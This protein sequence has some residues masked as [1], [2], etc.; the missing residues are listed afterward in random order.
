MGKNQ[1]VGGWAE[2]CGCGWVGGWVGGEARDG[3]I[4]GRR[5]EGKTKSFI[6]T[7]SLKGGV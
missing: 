1:R 3:R 5:G 7:K 4:G 6:K 2:E